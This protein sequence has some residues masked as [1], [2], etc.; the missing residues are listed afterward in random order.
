MSELLV[1]ETKAAK[2]NRVREKLVAEFSAHDA[3]GQALEKEL[4]L[5]DPRLI[6]RFVENVPEDH[7]MRL[8]IKQ[9][10]WHVIRK[11]EGENQI[12]HYLPILGPNGEYRPP[13]MKVAED[14]K[15]ADLWKVGALDRLLAQR[16]KESRQKAADAELRREQ[17]RDEVALAYRAAKRVP[18]DDKLM[19]EKAPE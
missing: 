1:V 8:G 3:Q 18:G 12:D 16:E 5:L 15:K 9:F 6:V 4:K 11:G 10:R 17:L 14:M 13:E 19:K 7:P 2:W